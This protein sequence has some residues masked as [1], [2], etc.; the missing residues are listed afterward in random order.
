MVSL[1]FFAAILY[2]GLAV[3]AA[4]ANINTTS[5]VQ[6]DNCDS[7]VS[8]CPKGDRGNCDPAK[9]GCMHVK[10]CEHIWWGGDCLEDFFWDG[11][12]RNTREFPKYENTIS[13]IGNMNQDHSSCHWF[14]GYN[15]QGSQYSNEW[16]ANLADGNG[17]WN[18]RISSY[19]C[20]YYTQ[21][22]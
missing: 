10:Y 14:D 22:Y 2:M 15:C 9:D 16:D 18:D 5:L 12:C 21:G 4:P 3:I 8:Y 6:L 11:E 7:T 17:W 1:T 19:R 13:S 20:D